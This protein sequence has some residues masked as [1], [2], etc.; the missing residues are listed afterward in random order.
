[1]RRLWNRHP[2]LTAIFAVALVVSLGF[3]IRAIVV[4]VRLAGMEDRPLAGWMTPRYIV[5]VYDVP[6]EVVS[7]VLELPEQSSP[8]QPLDAIARAQG[9]PVAE[10][11]DALRAAIAEEHGE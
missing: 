10:I 5:N 1:M 6:P 4:T 2:V 7:R 8:R 11:I 9:R 3:G